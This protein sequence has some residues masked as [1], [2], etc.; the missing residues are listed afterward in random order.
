M[1]SNY[2]PLILEAAG[3]YVGTA[4][5][6]GAK[7]NP[8]ISGFFAASGNAEVV[9]DEVPWCAAF[10]GAVLAQIGLQGTGKLNARSYEKWGLP[11]SLRD[12]KP[13]DIVVFWRESPQSWKGHVA[14][15]V[16]FDGADR[17]IVRGGNQDNTVKDESY[18]VGQIVAIRRG[19]KT[20]E[21][22]RP[23]LRYG[24]TGPSVMDL[25]DRLARLRYPVG[26]RDGKFG[27]L[28]R[29]GVL[30]FQADNGLTTDGIVGARTWATLVDAPPRPERDVTAADLRRSGSE[31]V[32][33]ADTGEVVVGLATAAQAAQTVAQAAQEAE[34]TLGV[35]TRLVTDHWPALLVLGA[36]GTVWLIVRQIR[37]ARVRDAR[38]G[39]HTGR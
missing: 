36:L 18:P 26:H 35:L 28:T 24:D 34:G 4:E 30:A 39:A 38:S 15:L 32:T 31:I 22:G 14:I 25:Q 2:N 12:A 11:V 9:S 5:W 3:Q 7:H 20:P 16:R 19:T 21:N 29:E 37:L 33:K 6:P 13:G 8:V 23:V 27:S 1:S 17:V 10:V